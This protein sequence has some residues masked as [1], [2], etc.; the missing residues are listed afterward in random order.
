MYAMYMTYMI[1]GAGAAVEYATVK[2]ARDHF[3]DFLDAAFVGRPAV[4]RR[5]S[6]RAVLVDAEWLRNRLAQ[7][8]PSN[9]EVVPENDGWS[10]SLPGLPIAADG[11]TL[12]EALED[13]VGALREY[14]E[15]WA[16]RLRNAP[17]HANNQ[18]V[19]TLTALSNDHQLIDWLTAAPR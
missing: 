11:T 18:D 16:A 9:A 12:D 17:N 5:E 6:Q 13:V 19:V 8:R 1:E 15:D 7:L 3:K 2:D 10:V 4:V 14:A